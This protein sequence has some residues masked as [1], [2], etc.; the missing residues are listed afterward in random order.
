MQ[1]LIGHE[2]DIYK[3]HRPSVNSISAGPFEGV[4]SQRTFA[5]LI[6]L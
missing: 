5:C 6:K 4:R 2:M 3:D 1:R